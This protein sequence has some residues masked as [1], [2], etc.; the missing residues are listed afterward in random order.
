MALSVNIVSSNTMDF[1]GSGALAAAQKSAVQA[2]ARDVLAKAEQQN[3]AVLGR[4]PAHTTTVDGRAGASLDDIKPSAGRI[5]FAFD[6]AA[7]SLRRVVVAALDALRAASPVV[8]GAYRDG[9]TLYLN[10]APM[11]DVPADI[12]ET[13]QIL[14]SNPV[15][16]SRRIEVGRTKSG[17]SFT[18]SA[19]PHVYERT[20]HMIATKYA[21]V[22][23]VDFFYLELPDAPHVTGRFQQRTPRYATGEVR[24]TTQT[25]WIGSGAAA[26]W[27]TYRA[28][29]A[30]TRIRRNEPGVLMAPALAIRPIGGRV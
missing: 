27:V 9:H 7:L 14:I 29:G 30:K 1:L 20:G 5:T 26:G 8:S 21:D 10:G 28:G 6:V 3:A 2:V 12:K 23:T 15:P 13:D 11:N 4:V 17:R 16:Y 22:A 24:K 25:H 18:I 19:K